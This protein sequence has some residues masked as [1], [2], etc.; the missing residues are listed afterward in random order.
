M[1][2]ADILK[3]LHVPGLGKSPL[4]PETVPEMGG[5]TAGTWRHLSK[6]EVDGVQYI[7]STQMI[8]EATREARSPDLSDRLLAKLASGGQWVRHVACRS[9]KGYEGY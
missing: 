1:C 4:P 9:L 5:Q 6:I 7:R 3:Q 8:T 2:L